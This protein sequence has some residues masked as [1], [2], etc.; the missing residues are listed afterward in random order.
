[1]TMKSKSNLGS[2]AGIA[3]LIA[4]V[5]ACIPCCIPLVAPILAWLGITTFGAALTGW[6]LTG[7]AVFALGLAA[8]IY[9]RVRRPSCLPKQS[10]PECDCSGSCKIN[11]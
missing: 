3:G 4:I 1:M 2:A 8:I 9:T 11:A 6:H 7:I 5:A 10:D